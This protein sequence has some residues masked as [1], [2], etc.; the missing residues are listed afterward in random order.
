MSK[1]SLAGWRRAVVDGGVMLVAPE[2]GGGLIRIRTR[3]AG[4][5]AL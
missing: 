4:D 5:S 3:E 1:L 2:P